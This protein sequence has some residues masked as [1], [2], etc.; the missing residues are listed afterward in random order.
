MTITT[1]DICEA[2]IPQQTHQI[3]KEV[4]GKAV[5]MRSGGEKTELREFSY[6]LKVDKFHF[7]CTDFALCKKC[8]IDAVSRS[9]AN[10]VETE[11]VIPAQAPA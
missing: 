11:R 9:V 1:C 7:S 8:L 6:E 2:V 3:A 10:I 5:L 4:R